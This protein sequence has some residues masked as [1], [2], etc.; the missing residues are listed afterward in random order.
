[1]EGEA[2][3]YGPK[4]DFV[5]YT[6]GGVETQLATIQLDFATPKRFGMKFINDKGEEETPVMVHRAILGSLERF[7]VII[8]EKTNG[9]LPFWLAPE[10]VRILTINDSVVEYVEEIT[11]VLE[12]TLLM[13][14]LKY[15]EV[16]FSVDNRNESLGK[17]IKE[18][19]ELR[20][21]VQLIVGPKDAGSRV[22]SVRTKDGESKMKIEELK[23]FLLGQ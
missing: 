19:T 6:V 17:K 4:L 5:Y 21:P 3:L 22:V 7:M 13:K 12:D 18:A 10:Q 11:S 9:W 14:P 23:D 2:A 1:M 8:L 15:N 16:R 20:I